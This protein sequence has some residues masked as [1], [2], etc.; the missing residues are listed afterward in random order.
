MKNYEK[1]YKEKS[2]LEKGTNIITTVVNTTKFYCKICPN[3]FYEDLNLVNY[4]D[5]NEYEMVSWKKKSIGLIV[6]IHGLMGTPKTLGY[7]IS[8]KISKKNIDIDII[9]PKIINKGNCSIE[10]SSEPLYQ[11][12]LD[13]IYI[14][15]KKPIHIISCSNGC[16]IASWIETKLRN[17]YVKIKLTCIA[18]AFGGSIVV[19][20]FKTL[21]NIVLSDE[22]LSELST[23]SETNNNL[24]KNMN[25]PINIGERYY[26]F[27]G[28]ANDLYIPNFNGCF[29][30]LLNDNNLNVKYHELKYGYDHV[31]LG[32][33]LSEEITTNS[34]KWINENYFN[35]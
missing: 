20:K 33:Y 18:G 35:L 17:L 15:P 9:L 24:K 26:E 12:L 2:I 21:L 22:I 29:P 28:T 11:L 32:W 4:V 25:E 31:S 27:Y 7:E 23:N 6:V 16:R 19:D 3:L 34:I 13:Y 8:K 10:K 1:E 30:L 14:N 5:N